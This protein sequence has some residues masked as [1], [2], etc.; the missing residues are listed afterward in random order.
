[1]EFIEVPDLGEV[2][3][4][5]VVPFE[6][7][8]DRKTRIIRPPGTTDSDEIYTHTVSGDSLYN[9]TNRDISL[10]NGDTMICKG[11]FELSEVTP[12]KICIVFIQTTCE[13]IAKKVTYRNGKV[14]LSASNPD[15]KDRIY[16]AND[17]EI[18]G[19]VIGFQ[20]N[21]F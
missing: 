4:G 5:T 6:P 14:I 7:R 11:N 13:R 21:F 8:S 12:N 15:Y 2:G 9:P 3:A 20:R 18:K 10:N 17:V 1:M 19:I 16:P